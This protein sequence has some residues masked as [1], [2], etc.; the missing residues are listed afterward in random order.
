MLKLVSQ[1]KIDVSRHCFV[2]FSYFFYYK[3]IA[4]LLALVMACYAAP[5]TLY[6]YPATA[7]TYSSNY[8]YFGGSGYPL[9]Y[10]A[11]SYSGSGYG[12]PLNA[13]TGTVPLGYI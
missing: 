10:S 5:N 13:Y 11:S 8:P 9:T 7:Y 6:G 4:T 12:I 1:T 3:L 2:L